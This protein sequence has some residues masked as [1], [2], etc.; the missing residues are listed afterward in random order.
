MIIKTRNESNELLLFRQ[1]NLRLNLL[2]KDKLYYSYLEKGYEGELA[3]DNIID[4]LRENWLIL[5]DLLLE[6]NNTTFQVDKV[7]ISPDKTYLFEV[8][9][10]EGDYYIEGDRWYL[11]PKTEIINPHVQLQRCES[12][13]R[14]LLNKV[15]FN[16]SIEAY[17]IFINPEFHLYNAPCNLPIVYPAQLKRFIKQITTFNLKLNDTHN[18]LADKLLSFHLKES[19]FT[20]VPKYNLNQCKKGMICPSCLKMYSN[21]S[22][23]G[24]LLCQFC[25][26][27]EGIEEAVLRSVD[28]YKILFP[29]QP[30]TTTIMVDW[31][32]VVSKKYVQKVLN[33]N[34]QLKR[35]GRSSYYI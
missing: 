11:T 23:N 21:K 18:K 2:E 10:Y 6:I 14:R 7:L 5:N 12:L 27:K 19:P 35:H 17:V 4:H 16:P 33:G 9:N 24:F 3:F 34:L 29:A 15:G 22:I 31:C 25:G 26:N 8:K 32:R 28:E 13:F 30:I 1:L 20:K